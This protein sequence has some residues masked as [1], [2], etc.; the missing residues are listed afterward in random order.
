[1]LHP[2]RPNVP[3]SE[4]QKELAHGCQEAASRGTSRKEFSETQIADSSSVTA[5]VTIRA[6]GKTGPI[7][8]YLYPHIHVT[9]RDG[10]FEFLDRAR[11]YLRLPEIQFFEVFQ[12]GKLLQA[13]IRN[14]GPIE[15]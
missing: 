8:L 15:V 1:M 5:F 13:R 3:H 12:S 4:I 2:G 9:V 6:T 10:F 11:G 14:L 7:L